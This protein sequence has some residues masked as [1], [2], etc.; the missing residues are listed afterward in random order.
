MSKYTFTPCDAELCVFLFVEKAWKVH[1]QGSMIDVNQYEEAMQG[2]T[3][4]HANDMKNVNL[5]QVMQHHDKM[6]YALD[7][8]ED[9]N[10]ESCLEESFEGW[11]LITPMTGDY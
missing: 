7:S 11:W 9:D 1:V 2:A 3:G 6:V 10:G 8:L 5:T 4:Y